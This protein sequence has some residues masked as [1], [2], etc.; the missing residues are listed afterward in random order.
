[1]DRLYW[2]DAYAV[3]MALIELYPDIDPLTVAWE[4]L[5]CWVVKLPDF[6]GDPD[7]KHLGWLRD[8]QKEWYEEVS[9]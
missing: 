3:A 2:D 9:S 6:S 8:I 1:M 7:L 4:T 5:H